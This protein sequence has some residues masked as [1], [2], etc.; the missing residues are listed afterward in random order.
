[1]FHDQRMLFLLKLKFKMF[2]VDS[3]IGQENTKSGIS[4]EIGCMGILRYQNDLFSILYLLLHICFSTEFN[5]KLCS[6][7]RKFQNFQIKPFHIQPH[8][9]IST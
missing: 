9:R 2:N 4:R 8:R 5:N 6:S 1:M 3:H 7:S